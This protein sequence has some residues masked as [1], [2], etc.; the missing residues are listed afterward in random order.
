VDRARLDISH[1][2]RITYEEL[3]KIELLANRTVMENVPVSTRWL[4]RTEAEKMF[5][6]ELYQ[7]GVPPGKD[8]RVVQVGD[9]VE[10][11]AGTHCIDTGMVGPIKVLRTERV[12]DG[13]ERIEFAA[14]EAAVLRG[15]E[16][17]GLLFGAADAL[18]VPP[19]QLPKTAARFFEEWKDLKKETARLKEDVARSQL[20]DLLSAAVPLDGLQ[21]VV[22]KMKNADVD[23]LI[24][25]ASMLSEK[26]YVVI[27]GS[28][29]KM[30]A[31]VGKTGLA[32]GLKAEDIIRIAA[33]VLGGGGGGKPQIAQGGG[34]NAEKLDEALEAG[35]EAVRS[36]L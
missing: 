25:T 36:A 33:K 32:R 22:Q 16:R 18:R 28:G 14:G 23:A 20:V 34:P 1:Y 19:D 31:A 27:L 15:Q 10:A 3:K 11:C 4:E 9:D 13:V 5:G 26:D 7:G 6:F 24:K 8:I 21:V 35:L 2:K 12:Q 17:D 29:G 30:V